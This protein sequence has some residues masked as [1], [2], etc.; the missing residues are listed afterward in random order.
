MEIPLEK[1]KVFALEA[2]GD[3]SYGILPYSV[4][5]ESVASILKNYGENVQIVGY[6]H[7]VLEDTE[8]AYEDI[9]AVF[10]EFIAKCVS[11][12]TD[13]PGE[14]RKERKR[15]TYDKLKKVSGE[16][17][18][19]LIVKAADRL[20]NLQACVKSNNIKL[21]KMY[22]KEHSDFYSA[23]YRKNLCEDIWVKISETI[24]A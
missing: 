21:L 12:T 17:E 18:L 2:H 23:T 24:N 4:H 14:N 16:L 19:A 22:Q 9:E 13:E 1:A 5:L 7:D 6:L 15:K 8:K 20:A 11:I 10:G 3:Q